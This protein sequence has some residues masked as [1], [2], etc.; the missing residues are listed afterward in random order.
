MKSNRRFHNCGEQGKL[1]KDNNR[2]EEPCHSADFIA[3]LVIEMLQGEKE[4]NTIANMLRN[5]KTEFLAN[6]S[7]VLD[8]KSNQ[9]SAERG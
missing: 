1:A 5:R 2:G 9:K 6:P 8:K 4:R 3:W 7:V